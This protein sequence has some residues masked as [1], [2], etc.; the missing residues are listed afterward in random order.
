[1][2]VLDRFRKGDAAVGAGLPTG[3]GSLADLNFMSA[4]EA[5]V[6]WKI[7][8][9]AYIDGTSEEKLD[10][11]VIEP[12]NNCVLG[13]WI[14]GSGGKRYGEHPLFEELKRIHASF[15][16]CA[17]D[18]VNKVD[19]GEKETA[20]KVLTTGEYPKYSHQVKALLARLYIELESDSDQP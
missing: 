19:G 13:K 17:A 16:R 10:A 5:H 18:V 7:R 14:H 3:V 12:D 20:L 9:Q 1:M 2:G 4:I 6:G 8:L 15:H 11:S